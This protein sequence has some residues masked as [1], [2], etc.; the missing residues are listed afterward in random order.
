MSRLGNP[1]PRGAARFARPLETDA[2]TSERHIE[3][4]E[5]LAEE[6]EEKAAAAPAP[7]R[8]PPAATKQPVTIRLTPAGVERLAELEIA[9]RRSGIRA[10]SASASEIVE[11][12]VR[13]ATPSE[14]LE[15]LK[16][17]RQA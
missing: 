6:E 12:L 14:L 16:P 1:A 10:R 2:K 9:L 5:P 11:A 8:R 17:S 4:T 3:A 13:S 7:V 15:L